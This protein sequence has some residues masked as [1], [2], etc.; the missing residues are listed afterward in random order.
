MGRSSSACRAGVSKDCEYSL[1][2]SSRTPR[3]TS[4][5]CSAESRRIQGSSQRNLTAISFMKHKALTVIGGFPA[6]NRQNLPSG[7]IWSGPKI[8]T[9]LTPTILPS[10]VK[11]DQRLCQEPEPPAIAPPRPRLGLNAAAGPCRVKMLNPIRPWKKRGALGIMLD[12]PAEF[13]AAHRE[14]RPLPSRT[15]L[16]REEAG[17]AEGAKAKCGAP[18]M[19]AIGRAPP[20]CDGDE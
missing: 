3:L 8:D 18:R 15:M 16:K 7:R 20:A 17:R 13:C 11:L 1:M 6:A 10:L 19:P 14:P 4:R 5:D 2:V 12:V 9:P